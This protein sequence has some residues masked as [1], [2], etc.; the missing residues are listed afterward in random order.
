MTNLIKS[1]KVARISDTVPPKPNLL[2][3]GGF[4]IWQRGTSFSG[5]SRFIADRWKVKTN[6]DTGGTTTH[7][8][9][10]NFVDGN[11]Y[12]I[13]ATGHNLEHYFIAQSLDLEA[14]PLSLFSGKTFTITYEIDSPNLIEAAIVFNIR[15]FD[16]SGNTVYTNI[17]SWVF[18][19]L[20]TGRQTKSHTITF[21]DLSGYSSQVQAGDHINF[22]LLLRENASN[23][24]L[25]DGTYKIYN[26]KLE[27][28]SN[29]TGWPHVDPTTELEKC[30][31]YYQKHSGWQGYMSTSSSLY[32]DWYQFLPVAMRATPTVT[33]VGGSLIINQDFS[34]KTVLEVNHYVGATTGSITCDDFILDAEL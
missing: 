15:T 20:T 6:T 3:N 2:I 22:H 27:E 9:Q 21:P 23:D 17:N 25:P 34:T 8:L 12:Q 13:Q 33:S 31:R 32:R 1:E 29:F 16:P 5:T 30:Q 26:I 11:Y 18:E 28:G 19:S 7:S 4:D 10:T 14:M 24:L